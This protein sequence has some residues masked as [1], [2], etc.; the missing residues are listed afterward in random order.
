MFCAAV[1]KKG[2]VHQCQAKCLL[3][4]V[5]CGRHAKAKCVILWADANKNRTRGV[6]R[7]QAL[8]RGWLVRR[9]LAMAGPGVLSRK[10]LANDEDVITYIEK[11]R[12]HPFSYFAFEENGKTWWFDFDSLYR[13]STHSHEP[14]NP[15]TKTPLTTDVRKRLRD[16]WSY[17]QRH[18][19]SLPAQ[20]PMFAERL[21]QRWNVICQTFADYGFGTIHPNLFLHMEKA[22][23]VVMFKM[24]REDLEIVL[25]DTDPNKKT[26][27]RWCA[28]TKTIANSLPLD[29]FILQAT[30][31]LFLCLTVPKDPYTTTFTALSALYRC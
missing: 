19:L 5:L 30:Y 9:R 15:Y 13:W 16:M 4:H 29:H 7:C 2:S 12:Q 14:S 3:G 24:M 17:R 10:D 18:Q 8:V 23:Y 20:S 21:R 11:E 1:K 31:T 26:L 27:L 25:K 6:I 22:Q 28:R